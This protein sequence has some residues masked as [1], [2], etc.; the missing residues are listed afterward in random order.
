MYSFEVFFFLR[1]QPNGVIQNK[2]I[3]MM[4]YTS[5]GHLVAKGLPLMNGAALATVFFLKFIFLK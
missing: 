4:K 1:E 3:T 2:K 5:F